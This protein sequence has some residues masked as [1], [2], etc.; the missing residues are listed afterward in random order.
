MKQSIQVFWNHLNTDYQ[1]IGWLF[2]RG[3]A[4]IYFAAFFSLVIQIERLVGVNGILPLTE[5][6]QRLQ[7]FYPNNAFW[8]HPSVFWLNAEDWVLK[9]ACYVG[10]LSSLFLFFNRFCRSAL[11]LNFIL[12]LSLSSAGQIFTLFQW[13]VFLL[14]IGL[15]AIFHSWG[16]GIVVM[17]FR[18]LLARFMFMGGVVKLA[19]GDPHWANLTALNFHYQT[20]PLPTPLAYYAHHLPEWAHKF[21][22]ASVFFIELIVPFFVFMPRKF[23]LFA[24]FS[25]MLLQSCI[26]LTGNYNFFNVSVMLLCLFL[27]EDKDVQQLTLKVSSLTQ[28]KPGMIAHRCA[29][30][31]AIIVMVACAAHAWTYHSVQP[32]ATP[33]NEVVKFV[34][35]FSLVNNYGP[36]AVMTT[37]R[38]EIIVQG[39]NDGVNWSDYEFKY[40]PGRLARGLS[41]NIP[42]QPRLDWQMWF[43]ALKGPNQVAWL[44]RFILKLLLDSPKVT[45]LL[46]ENPFADKPP[47]WIRAVKY[48]YFYTSPAQRKI[49]RQLWRRDRYRIFLPARALQSREKI[50]Y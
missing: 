38:D 34:A 1:R 11:I 13:D 36:F 23:R 48:R 24:C 33:L 6:L 32:L 17:L 7:Q 41:W 4:L 15:L 3:L 29:G 45:A 28:Y 42:H 37:T 46:A 18:W 20:Q 16:S 43:A 30:I 39:S 9:F 12:Y 27:L 5:H 35:R 2:Q 40:K 10:L 31:W 19:S 49:N 26:I 44:E 14:E 21:S 22:V 25:F 50:L 8:L 47:K